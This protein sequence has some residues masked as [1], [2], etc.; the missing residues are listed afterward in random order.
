MRFTHIS[1]L[2]LIA[3]IS[4]LSVPT[5]RAA[6]VVTI[7]QVG[8]DVVAT[9]SGS[10]DINDLSSLGNNEFLGT[11]VP[12]KAEV[13]V[14]STDGTLNNTTVY[15]TISGPASFGSGGPMVA[16]SGSGAVVGVGSG[17]L[18]V[19]I[20]YSSG[21]DLGTSTDTWS[22]QSLSSLGLTPGT[23][24]FTLP[25]DTVTVN[26]VAVPEPANLGLLTLAGIAMLR[27]RSH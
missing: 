19:P 4:F 15:Q 1:T 3:A 11:M 20:N 14:G 25:D 18:I 6:Y 16:T 21:A 5:T 10:L 22:S 8:S 12:Q 27:R 23:Y 17:V 13:V 26:V 9:G 2:C 24:N 7:Q